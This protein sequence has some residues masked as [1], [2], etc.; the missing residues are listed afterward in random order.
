[1]S[2]LIH[3]PYII[4]NK[5]VR[6]GS[7]LIEDDIIKEIFW[8]DV[9]EAILKNY[10]VIEAENL[11]LFPGI[12]DDQVHFREPGLTYKGDIESESK[13]AVAGGITSYLEMPNTKP[14]TTS[15]SEI[16]FKLKRASETSYTNYG[17]YIGATNENYR[18]ICNSDPALIAG[19]KVFLGSS[20]GNMLV[21]N[22]ETLDYIFENSK[23]IVAVHSEDETIIKE[24]LESACLKYG[25]NI[26]PYMHAHIRNHESCISSTRKAISRAKKFGTRLHIL[27]L[28]TAGE[29][30]MLEMQNSGKHI[31][32]ECCI[33][34]L[35]FSDKDYH[36]LGNKIKWNPSI[37]TDV[38][39]DM[40]RKA[41]N[42][43]RIDMIATDH[44]PHTWEEKQRP[45]LDCPSGGPMVQHSLQ[46]MLDLYHNGVFS[47]ETIAEKMCHAP[48]RI[49]NISKR[50][51]IKKGFYADLVL[52]DLKKPYIVAK[53]NI[54]YKCGWS[55]FEGHRFRSSVTHT[56]VNGQLIYDNGSFN[57]IRSASPLYF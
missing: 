47:L 55:P 1:M 46:A 20:T 27:H 13:A 45:Y 28:S 57:N 14:P 21:D 54:M 7:L 37:K 11:H 16:E 35:W 40:L 2:Y 8:S 18:E 24:G 29:C 10:P 43:G 6:K 12:I 23:L 5:E 38:D 4:N 19:I 25:N 51:Y 3:Q 26:P 32:A 42:D 48:A 36:A 9:P 30:E 34:H 17:F 22:E 44:A 41:V 53:D 31:T 50:G 49:F 33:H 39:R 52:A 15:I 56:F